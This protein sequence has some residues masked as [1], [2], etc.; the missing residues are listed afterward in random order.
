MKRP[1][2]WKKILML[3]PLLAVLGGCVHPSTTAAKNSDFCLIAEPITVEDADVLTDYTAY[4]I[5]RHNCAL[6]E[7]CGLEESGLCGK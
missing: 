4:M 3:F 6:E 1:L 2:N 7:W 5:T